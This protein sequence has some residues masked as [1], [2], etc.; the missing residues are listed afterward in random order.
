MKNIVIVGATSEIGKQTALKYCTE[1]ASFV[2]VARNKDKLQSVAEELRAKGAKNVKTVVADLALVEGHAGIIRTVLDTF[3]G[4]D[5]VLLCHGV[6][7][8]NETM[9]REYENF[10]N[11]FQTNTLSIISFVNQLITHYRPPKTCV[12]GI[13]SSVAGVRGRAEN[14][15]YGASKAALTTYADGLRARMLETNYHILTILPGL[16]TTPMTEHLKH[17]IL[18]SSAEKVGTDIYNAVRCRRTKIFTPFWWRYIMFLVWLLPEFV[19]L[20]LAKRAR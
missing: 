10:Y 15:L 7:S 14:F 11:M 2:L 4:I 1:G 12:I 16:T 8:N 19:A 18:Y 9:L 13:I 3:E 17:N 6:L 5:V 20:R